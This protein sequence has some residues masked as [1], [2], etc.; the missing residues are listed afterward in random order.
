MVKSS[1]GRTFKRTCLV[2][3]L[4]AEGRKAIIKTGGKRTRVAPIRGDGLTDHGAMVVDNSRILDIR[5]V[6][7]ALA[8]PGPLSGI[9]GKRGTI[10]LPA[11]LRR[12][13]GLEAGS[14]FL[15]EER[16]GV[17]VIR[18]ADVV[19]RRV[20]NAL[21]G[22]LSGVTAENIHDEVSTG[23]AVGGKAW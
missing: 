17:V 10:V 19:P 22:L 2:Q 4:E 11:A 7:E 8:T 1:G 14:A 21:D 15:L 13:H 3:G 5:P 16:E 9:V 6:E 20:S 18:P 12:R 23:N